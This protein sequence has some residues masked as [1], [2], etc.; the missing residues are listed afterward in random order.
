MLEKMDLLFDDLGWDKSF[1]SFLRSEKDQTPYSVIKKSE[2]ELILVHNVLGINKEDLEI[3]LRSEDGQRVLYITGETKDEKTNKKYSINSRFTI[4]NGNKIKDV[5]S[6]AKNGL[7][8][9]LKPHQSKLY[10]Y[11]NISYMSF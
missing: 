10:T 7:L 2:D 6:E 4:K 8:Y 3:K 1:Y 5:T 11:S 9:C